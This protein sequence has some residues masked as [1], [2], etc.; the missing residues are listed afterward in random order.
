MRDDFAV[1]ITTH[2]RPNQQKSL[3]W[4]LSHGYTGKWFLV[5]DDL[6]DTRGSYV[7]KYR[8]HVLI[9]DKMKY[10]QELDTFNNRQ[11]LAAVLYARQAVEDFARDMGLSA[12]CVMDDDISRF[13][14]RVPLQTGKLVRNLNVSADKFMS[15]YVDFV[16]GANIA[17]LC[18]GTQNMYMA[19]SCKLLE[20]LPGKGSNA[21]FRNVAIPVQWMSAMNEDLITCIDYNKRGVLMCSALLIC[22]ESSNAGTGK[23]SGGMHELYKVM[24]SYER[25]FYAVMVDPART[26]LKL[27]QTK[28]ET[29]F[30]IARKWSAGD[31]CI[32]GE[33]WRK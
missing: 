29:K 1:F 18:P 12:F 8:D 16:L 23:T 10:W 9:F 7:E 31:P 25:T 32:I 17:S 2:G 33:R 13:A 11:H 21:F 20:D 27:S 24:S 26:F 14:A 5:V 3:D 4:L 28:S 22:C 6:D 15:A 19:N 30:G